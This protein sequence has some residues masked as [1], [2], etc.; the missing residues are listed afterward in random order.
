MTHAAAL[1]PITNN[2]SHHIPIRVATSN[3]ISLID[4]IVSL[5]INLL[6]LMHETRPGDIDGS[7]SETQNV[8]I[9]LIYSSCVHCTAEM[10]W[11]LI[12]SQ[13]EGRDRDKLGLGRN[14]AKNCVKLY[15]KDGLY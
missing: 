13:L 4:E 12:I 10:R 8:K 1:Y 3:D 7:Q 5:K 14:C 2:I 11:C 15:R 6:S 9:R